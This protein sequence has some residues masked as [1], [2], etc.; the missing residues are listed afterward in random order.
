METELHEKILKLGS[1]GHEK[2]Y[3]NIRGW[4]KLNY[5]GGEGGGG[6]KKVGEGTLE[7]KQSR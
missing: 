3:K 5:G 6:E 7:R 2:N 4:G 1:G